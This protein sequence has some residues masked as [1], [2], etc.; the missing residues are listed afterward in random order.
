[1][2]FSK[3]TADD[4]HLFNEGTH[5]RLYDKFGA[6]AT[7]VGDTD[8][9]HFAVWAPNAA[10]VSVFGSFNYWTKGEH[11]LERIGS[12][13]IWQ[14]FIPGIGAGES[15]KYHIESAVSGYAVDKADPVAAYAETPPETGSRIWDLAYPWGDDAWM[16][17]RPGWAAHTEPVSIYELHIGSWR[18]RPE[19]DNRPLTYREMAEPLAD[20]VSNLGFTHVEML[21]VME[22]PFG[23]S[24]GYQTTGYFAPTARYGTPQDFMYLVDVL[25]QRGIGVIIDWVPSHFATDEHGL[26]FFDGTH[27]YEHADH[28]QG[29]HPD[30]GSLIFN[31]D[32]NEV[33]SFLMSSAMAWLDRYHVD[34][35]RV[36]A[37]ASMLYLDYS[38]KEG[39]WIPNVY[40]GRE[41]LGAVGFLR[42]FNRTVYQDFPGVQTF[43]EEST[44][45]P[46][47][48]RPLE[49]GGLGFGFKW[50]MGWMHDTL[51]Y[52]QR[53]P[54]HRKHHHRD[55]TFRGLYGFTENFCLP[56]S[57]DEVVH[58]KS[59]LLN[60]MAGDDW[61]KFANLRLLFA[62]QFAVPGKKLLFMG[63]ELAQRSEWDHDASVEWHLLEH[64]S[65]AGVMR[66]VS[67]VAHLYR[68]TPALHTGD[69]DPAGLDWVS[70]DQADMS[71]LAFLRTTPGNDDHVLVVFNFTPVPRNG[72]A[73]GVP[74]SGVWREI[75][76]TDAEPYWGSGIGNGGSVVTTGR[77]HGRFADSLSLTVP[78]LG[79][80]FLAADD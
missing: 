32:R 63:G 39:E 56:L 20:H 69:H 75:L 18:R 74:K 43:A 26:G 52:L 2:P 35:I 72:F 10:S 17:A 38:R 37:V 50:D 57:H 48:S 76:N 16:L 67:D 73:I 28:R 33:R 49:S 19:E 45:W 13:G 62:Y 25:H 31:Y 70:A 79:A 41:N 1:M 21:P 15:Y 53:D 29:F 22:H 6:H 54:V 40:G 30:W 4:L 51:S 27:L 61:Q 12:S 34:G 9:T 68:A 55:L 47:V 44:A 36:D 14:G 64:A 77:P 78:P 11:A 8:G 58:G 80:V 7:R 5:S 3:L 23:G 59:S 66:L 60:K 42:E 46:N 24:W 71:A 65:H